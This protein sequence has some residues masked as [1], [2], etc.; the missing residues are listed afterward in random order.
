MMHG[1]AA[2][3]REYND[4]RARDG[5]RKADK[6]WAERLDRLSSAKVYHIGRWSGDLFDKKNPLW[7]RVGI[8]SR[9]ADGRLRV[10][11]TGAARG[12]AGHVL[13]KLLLNG[14]PNNLSALAAR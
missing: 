14:M 4:A 10:L 6:E 3:M 11:N 13:T 8:V 9:G 12:E 1:Y 7:Q 5:S 2:L